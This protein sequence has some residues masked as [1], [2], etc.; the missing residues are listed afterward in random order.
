[1]NKRGLAVKFKEWRQGK[2]LYSIGYQYLKWVG[3]TKEDKLQDK[4]QIDT[5]AIRLLQ[6]T[7]SHIL[8]F[9][10][11]FHATQNLYMLFWLQKDA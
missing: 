5:K 3:L 8:I 2:G 6:T 11:Y 7:E 1:M 4:M 10:N 9:V